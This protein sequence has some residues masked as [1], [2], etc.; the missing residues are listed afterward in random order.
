MP[1]EGNTGPSGMA[2]DSDG[3]PPEPCS[4]CTA[5]ASHSIP[6]SHGATGFLLVANWGNWAVEVLDADGQ[7]VGRIRCPF[8]TPGNLCFVP[9]SHHVLV[10]EHDYHA[11]WSFGWRTT[12]QPLFAEGIAPPRAAVDD[13]SYS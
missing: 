12:G 4:G 13:R 11:V 6:P 8:R 1:G 3:T 9:D 10:S 7:H 2:F 5:A